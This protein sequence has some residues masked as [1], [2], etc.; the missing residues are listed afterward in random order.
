[1]DIEQFFKTSPPLLE[2]RLHAL[3]PQ[4]GHVSFASLFEAARYSL[5]SGGKRL[6]PLL[7]LASV[8]TLGGTVQK[9]LDPACAIELIHTYSLIHD[10]LPCMDDDHLRR[11]KPTLHRVY[12]EWHAL[13]AGDYLLTYAFEVISTCPH[14]TDTEKVAIIH[15]L[16]ERSGGHG[17]I[18]GQMIDL[19]SE[20]TFI[21]KALLE[22]MH[23]HKTA[24][25]ISA[26]LECGAIIAQ[27]SSKDRAL[28]KECGIKIGLA[29]QIADDILDALPGENSDHEQGK[30]TAVSLLGLEEALHYKQALLT[31]SLAVLRSLSKPT[32]LLET[33]FEKL[34]MRTH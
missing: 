12:P 28:L 17:M 9:A 30:A 25:L 13:L 14:L 21:D 15:V 24:A 8:H 20:G 18:G 23:E 19:I 3:I 11:G 27:A 22:Q 34:A 4:Q 2:E 6:R 1:M 29:F 5:F 26:A 33:L 10:D 31:E 7:M 16:S 32:H